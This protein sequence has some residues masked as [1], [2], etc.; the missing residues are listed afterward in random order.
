MKI[1]EMIPHDMPDWANEGID[2]GQFFR[3]CLAKVEELENSLRD[4]ASK[5]ESQIS[6]NP[7]LPESYKDLFN[8]AFRLLR[9]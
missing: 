5:L 6:R 4:C 2:S 1:T 9:K 7:E 8:K 3:V